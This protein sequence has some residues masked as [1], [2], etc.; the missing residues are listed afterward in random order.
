MNTRRNF[1][2][3]L[4][5]AAAVAAAK[6]AFDSAQ[7]R[8]PFEAPLEARPEIARRVPTDGPNI[9][10]GDSI[11][12]RFMDV[13]WWTFYDRLA[14]PAG[15]RAESNLRFFC[16]PIGSKDPFSPD[17]RRQM[18]DTNM[19]LS[20]RLEDP[21]RMAISEFAIV[22]CHHPDDPISTL[23]N[24]SFAELQVGQKT[25]FQR[26]THLAAF[27]GSFETLGQ[28][29]PRALDAI[30]SWN[31]IRAATT[32]VDEGMRI[33][34]RVW[35]TEPAIGLLQAQL[36]QGIFTMAG[37]WIWAGQKPIRITLS[38]SGWLARP[39]S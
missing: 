3:C 30:R 10:F 24:N 13:V 37:P 23:V 39:A 29:N 36:L 8:N 1:F 31:E 20:S 33:L 19:F 5:G 9:A 15:A 34:D 4:T 32:E 14:I 11:G 35:D 6:P 21:M 12:S 16:N 2:K 17:R 38:I 22:F 7:L 26:S 18:C 27:P 28:H 25:H